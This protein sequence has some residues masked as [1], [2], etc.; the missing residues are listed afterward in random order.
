MTLELLGLPLL[1]LCYSLIHSYVS[2]SV[3][4]W[5]SGLSIFSQALCPNSPWT[6]SP[7]GSWCLS[8][9]YLGKGEQMPSG[10]TF[11]NLLSSWPLTLYPSLGKG[12]VQTGDPP[13]S[14]FSSLS[15]LFVPQSQMPSS[16]WRVG[17][18]PL[19]ISS[20]SIL[21]STQG[22]DAWDSKPLPCLLLCHP[23]PKSLRAAW[24]TAIRRAQGTRKYSDDHLLEPQNLLPLLYIYT[25]GN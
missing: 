21:L 9:F 19:L 25:Y 11:P 7:L 16:D 14:T 23:S 2:A 22:L 8:R 24:A 1:H 5:A 3:P 20:K 12:V 13:A 10:P 18:F 15:L 17:H 4:S 6:L